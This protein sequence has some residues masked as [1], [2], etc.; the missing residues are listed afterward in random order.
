MSVASEGGGARVRSRAALAWGTLAVGVAAFVFR[1][2][3]F[4]R[5]QNDH[6]DHVARARQVLLG[7][8]PV[9]DFVDPGLPLQYLLSA[10][11]HELVGAPVLAEALIFVASLAVAAALS[12]RLAA[13]ASG[14][15]LVALYAVVLQ[16]AFDPRSYSSPK[17]LVYA[18]ALAVGWWTVERPTWRRLAALA[19]ATAVAYYFRH[20]HGVYVGLASV[21]LLAV[22]GWRDGVRPVA[23]VLAVYAAWTLAFV[24]PHLAYVE[25][26][27]GLLAYLAIGA[28]YSRAELAINPRSIPPFTPDA[29]LPN[30]IALVFWVVWLAPVAALLML[31]RRETIVRSALGQPAARIAMLAVLA[32]L[33]NVGFVRSPAVTRLP[34]VAVPHTILWAWLLATCWRMAGPARLRVWLRAATVA[35]AVTTGVAVAAAFDLREKLLRTGAWLGPGEVVLRLHEMADAFREPSPEV[36]PSMA[37]HLAPFFEYLQACTTVDDRLL[38]VG[39]EP[40]VFVLAG[41][42]FAGGHMMFFGDF[43]TSPRDQMLTIA[44][45]ERESVPFVIVPESKLVDFEKARGAEA[46]YV[47]SHYRLLATLP[48]EDDRYGVYVEAARVPSSRHDET[49]WPCF[50]D[51]ERLATRK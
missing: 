3:S 48:V 15:L 14:S 30:G 25:Y 1:W 21:V 38:F 6:F 19:A 39:Y 8:W 17:L 22:H 50:L 42:G 18:I 51:S 26:Y 13:A 44:R 16:L 41:R 36:L 43:H 37:Q 5:F 11:V 35:A 31:L 23:R 29:L 40:Q 10:A 33:V 2:L 45:L 4:G 28:D 12:F 46:A 49:G 27:G 24:L 7:E 32:L 34:D 9:R 20:D 47:A